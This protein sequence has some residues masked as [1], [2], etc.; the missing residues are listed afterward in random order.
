MIIEIKED[1]TWFHGSNIKFDVLRA[2]STVTQW[3][4]LAEAFSHQP[5]G[6][7]YDACL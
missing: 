7:G 3:Q 2:E 6:L 4:E 1:G 5:S